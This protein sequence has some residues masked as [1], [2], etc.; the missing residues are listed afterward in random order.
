MDA[1]TLLTQSLDWMQQKDACHSP[2]VGFYLEKF[3]RDLQF[4]VI[5]SWAFGAVAQSR[6]VTAWQKEFHHAL[7]E[8][9]ASA[10]LQQLQAHSDWERL[11]QGIPDPQYL[12]IHITAQ[13]V[14]RDFISEEPMSLYKAE[15]SAYFYHHLLRWKWYLLYPQLCLIDSPAA[16]TPI[17]K[18]RGGERRHFTEMQALHGPAKPASLWA[19]A[20]K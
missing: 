6:F 13:K 3:T 10:Y 4:P 18:L 14:L 16:I 11:K 19:Q 20:L 12:L 9:G 5:E 7:I 17:V 15:D 2:F 8:V 1:S